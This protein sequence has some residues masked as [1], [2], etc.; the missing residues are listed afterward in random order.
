MPD[1]DDHRRSSLTC[2]AVL[3]PALNEAENLASLLPRLRVLSV[4]Q[5]IVCDNGSTDDTRRVTERAGATWAFEPKRGYGAACASGL[6]RLEDSIDIVAFLD[7]DSVD[8]SNLLVDL[9]S[10]IA[11]GDA[12]LVLGARLPELREPG[13]TTFPQRVANHLFPWLIRMGWG[14]GYRDLGPLR[15]IRRTSLDQMGMRDRA[16]GWTIEMQIRAVEMRLRILEIPVRHRARRA[17]KSKVSGNLR[18]TIRAARGITQTWLQLW[19]T[20][21][22]RQIRRS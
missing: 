22:E 21:R 4:G 3:V 12:D 10:P 7:A 18:G 8:D 6:A 5:V 16:Y 9:C 1:H 20:K 2:L 17:G 11:R 19:W 15:A 13:S 14:F